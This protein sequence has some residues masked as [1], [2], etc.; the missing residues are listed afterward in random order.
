MCVL[1]AFLQ[2]AKINLG[3]ARF[4]RTYLHAHTN[5]CAISENTATGASTAMPTIPPR[6]EVIEETFIQT[7]MNVGYVQSVWH[8]MVAVISRECV[9]PTVLTLMCAIM[10]MFLVAARKFIL[11]KDRKR[12][13]S[14]THAK[15]L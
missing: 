5:A 15:T 10:L 9:Y 11:Y 13:I 4:F 6:F 14:M 12:Y 7:L 8:A 3:G 1:R 2:N